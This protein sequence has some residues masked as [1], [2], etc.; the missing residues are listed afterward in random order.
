MASGWM[1]ETKKENSGGG[2]KATPDG[3]TGQGQGVI[4]YWLGVIGVLFGVRRDG[5]GGPQPSIG[6]CM[7]RGLSNYGGGTGVDLEFETGGWKELVRWI[8]SWQPDVKV[9]A[10][11][12]LRERVNEKMK[13]A[14]S[15]KR[16]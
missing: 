11:R 14:L 16:R 3:S 10:P 15:R 13:Q 5:C 4:N 6:M 9:L 7:S 12:R 8:L 1:S 2:T